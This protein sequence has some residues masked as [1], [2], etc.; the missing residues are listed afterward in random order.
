MTISELSEIK[1]NTRVYVVNGAWA[2]YFISIRSNLI[3][4]VFVVNMMLI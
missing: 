2:G 3:R 4:F 1:A